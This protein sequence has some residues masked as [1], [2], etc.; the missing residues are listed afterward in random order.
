[1]TQFAEADFALGAADSSACAGIVNKT[2][3]SMKASRQWRMF[4]WD[5]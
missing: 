5:M 4:S 3:P 2:I 1:L